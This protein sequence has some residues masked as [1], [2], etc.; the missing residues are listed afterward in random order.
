MKAD[1]RARFRCTSGCEGA[2]PIEQV[3]YRCPRCG[4]LLEVHHDIEALREKSGATWRALLDARLAP[5]GFAIRSGV[6]DKREWVM[7][8]LADTEIVSLG[9]GRSVLLDSP[10]LAKAL[11]VGRLAVKQCGNA[12][13][14]SFKDLGMTVLISCVRYM[15]D[16][17]TQVPAI[18]CASTGDTS[19]SLAAYAAAAG[20]PA[21]V[22]LPRGMVTSEQLV[23]PLCHGARVLTVDTDFDGCMSLVQMLAERDGVYL[24]N[25]MNSLRLEGQKTVAIEI[26][27]D[28]G[29][30]VPDWIVIPGG[31]LGNVSALGAGLQMML[32]LGVI[33]RAPRIC[34]AQAER[35]NPL[36]Q[37]FK[38]NFADFRPL[39]A[40]ATLASAIRIGN[41]VSYKKAI[42]AVQRFEGV[43]EQ[44]SEVELAEAVATADRC[45]L[46][47]CPHTGV[48]LAAVQKLRAAGTIRPD[49][50]V[51]VVSTA[52]GLKFSEFKTRYH[53]RTLAD[54]P[55]P[56]RSNP[57][58]EVK[59]DYGAVRAAAL[60]TR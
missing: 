51:V 19:A 16:K 52:N 58:I 21:V 33:D 15:I 22:I 1:Y 26:V 13:T 43:V 9:E 56:I 55:A 17:G 32:D 38:K 60:A 18:V 54:V 44:A 50:D 31:N 11:G 7:P 12:H 3:I 20:L 48:A 57:P 28:R 34:V 10:M 41:P 39:T 14:G 29:W 4:D 53:T 49:D 40:Q 45:G 46:Y 36:Y 35:A 25:S 23:Q 8:M 6:W 42:R 24:A 30:R 5:G 2:F 27:Q 59:N 37:S 47:T